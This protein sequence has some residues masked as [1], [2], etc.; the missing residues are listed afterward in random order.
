MRRAGL[1]LFTGLL[2]AVVLAGGSLM[3]RVPGAASASW[4]ALPV[5]VA[6]PARIMAPSS[7]ALL[8]GH[9]GGLERSDDGGQSWHDVSLP[10]A[11]ADGKR[12]VLTVDPTNH[13]AIFADGAEG[14]YRSTD[15]A[16]SWDLVLPGGLSGPVVVSPADPSVVYALDA[17]GKDAKILRSRDGGTNWD[18]ASSFSLFVP[19]EEFVF[20][21]AHPTDPSRVF[22]ATR[23][24]DGFNPP[25]S[26]KQSLDQGETWTDWQPPRHGWPMTLDGGV[27]A[28]PARYFVLVDWLGDSD[29]ALRGVS[30][31]NDARYTWELMRTTDD[32][33]T[34]DSMDPRTP[35]GQRRGPGRVQAPIVQ[36]PAAPDRLF[37]RKT[38]GGIAMSED[39]GATWTPL[40]EGGPR[41]LTQLVL[42]VDGAN[43]Y[44]LDQ[45]GRVYRLPLR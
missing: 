1:R 34:W 27:P 29:P 11:P 26:L 7:G 43:L 10:P 32:G 16:A 18:Q 20:L 2:V 45:E 14:L 38:G 21:Q 35:S 9:A 3:V 25:G 30:S 28:D 15:D 40:G 19:F 6:M 33:Q 36:D 24:R 22:L 4:E 5:S 17:D 8:V 12:R 39:S 23:K 42:G 13:F 41:E 31:Q 44:A 37:A